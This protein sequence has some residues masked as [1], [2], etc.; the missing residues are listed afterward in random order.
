MTQPETA[1]APPVGRKINRPPILFEK[2]QKIIAEIEDKTGRPFLTYWNSTRGSVC[3]NDVVGLYEMLRGRKRTKELVLFVKSGGGTGTA[4]LRMVHLLRN[5]ASHLIAA[6]PLECQSAATMLVLGANR[7]LMGPLAY[8]TP[9][10]T[11]ITHALSPLDRDND[12]VSVS[13]DELTRIVNLWRKEFRGDKANPYQALFGHVHPLVIGAVDRAR[14]LSIMLCREILS[15]HLKTPKRAANISM[16]LNAEYPAHSYPITLREARRIGIPAEALDPVIND[17]LLELNE[18][19]SEMGQRAVTDFDE[20]NFHDNE[21]LNILESRN[22]QVFYQIDKDMHYRKEERRW[23]PLNDA[24]GWRKM[25]S[26]D[27]QVRSSVFHIR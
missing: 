8:L 3:H 18:L 15:Y 22:M 17:H 21:I 27:G 19:Y 5:H 12:L 26:E 11:S 4:A 24:S 2:T 6:V 1:P 10:D 13:Q 16:H 20:A 23:V 25:E 14:S 7:I 9:I